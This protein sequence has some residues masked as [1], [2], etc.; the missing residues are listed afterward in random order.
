MKKVLLFIAVLFLLTSY[1]QAQLKFTIK[2]KI[3]GLPD[4]TEVTLHPDNVQSEP[5]TKVI[6]KKG[7]FT[8]KG[9]IKEP[10]IYMLTYSGSSQALALFLEG[11]QYKVDANYG[12]F[13]TAKVQG[14]K[15]Q[16]QYKSF[17]QQ[18]DPLF[19]QMDAISRQIN[20]PVYSAQKDSL[21]VTLRSVITEIDQKTDEYVEVE[22]NSF[23]SPLLLLFVYNFFQQPEPL[24]NR[25]RKL[26]EPVKKSYYGRMVGKIIED[27]RIGAVGSE[28][29]DF[30]QADTSGTMVSLSSFRGKYVLVD[31]WASWCGPCRMENPNVVQAY[32]KFKDRNFTVLGISLDRSKEAWMQ[33]IKD[34]RLNW[35]QLSDLKFWSNEVARMY[36][37]SSIPQNILIDP[38]G[39]IISKNLRGEDLLNKLQ[40][41]LGIGYTQNEIVNVPPSKINVPGNLE[42][43]ENENAFKSNATGF[44]INEKGY[45][46]TN[47]H[48]VKGASYIQ[49]EYVI[50][51][52]KYIYPAQVIL[53]DENNDLAVLKINDLKFEPIPTIPYVFS[54]KSMEL[55]VEVFTIGYPFADV[56]GDAPKYSNG[57]ISS[58]SGI[59]D[60]SRFYQISA[61]LQP[62][63][64]GGPL[65]DNK[66]NLIGITSGGLN[67][68][69]FNSENVNYAIKTIL[70]KELINKLPNKIDLPN[71]T[72]IYNLSIQ[73][74]IKIIQQFVPIIRVK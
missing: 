36:K 59:N 41:L 64:S 46:V 45:L 72:S 37:I 20:D 58:L 40:E 27:L 70:L 49:V 47:Y 34:D 35:T 65:F 25:Y 63:N 48:V 24:E 44:F 1:V 28:A 15:I 60:D 39:V 14:G 3:T 21:Y 33:A 31:F 50:N 8:F 12:E 74:K 7:S 13:F 23:V 2:G 16:S 30:Q 9:S 57:H 56:M 73:D 11:G 68:E 22:K 18:F 17:Q 19:I 62:G 51:N 61:P 32:E 55:G 10:S 52:I 43:N 6:S 38:N 67:K 5:I 29:V 26:T 42:K 53:Y 69:V 71:N 4:S 66:G 54:S